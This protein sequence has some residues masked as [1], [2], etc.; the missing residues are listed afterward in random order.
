MHHRAAAF[1]LLEIMVVL[2]IA[3]LII[4][5]GAGA[6]QNIT[7]ENELR[8]ASEGVEGL[9]MKA[10]H[11]AY[12]SSIPQ[13]VT[14]D[15]QGVVTLLGTNPQA[16]TAS[17]SVAL[18]QGT[19][20]MLRRMGADKLVPAAGQRVLMRPGGLCEP[21][22]LQFTWKGSTLSASLDPLT[23]GFTDVEE[24]LQP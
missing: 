19:R 6:L 12:A 22:L 17:P 4:V 23:G 10:V 2:A 21:L 9:F 18:P 24:F 1:T 7:E 16:D 5:I 11:Q 8:K 20:L 3:A 14:F 13:A 15:E